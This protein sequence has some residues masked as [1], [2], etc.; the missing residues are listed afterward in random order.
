[1]LTLS[2]L[3]RASVS[4]LLVKRYLGM[5]F[6]ARSIDYYANVVLWVALLNKPEISLESDRAH[7]ASLCVSFRIMHGLLGRQNNS[8]TFLCVGVISPSYLGAAPVSGPQLLTF[9]INSN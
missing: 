5:W 8:L 7:Y 6:A 1:M 9:V 2:W 3:C 4:I